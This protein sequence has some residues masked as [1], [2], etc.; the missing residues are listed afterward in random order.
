LIPTSKI[1]LWV[2]VVVI[3]G[4][5]IMIARSVRQRLPHIGSLRVVCAIALLSLVALTT[6]CARQVHLSGQVFTSLDLTQPFY[7]T[8]KGNP[9]RPASNLGPLSV[10]DIRLI[11]DGDLDGRVGRGG[12]RRDGRFDLKIASPLFFG[13]NTVT[14]VLRQPGFKATRFDLSVDKVNE[15]AASTP[16]GEPMFEFWLPPLQPE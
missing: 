6:G 1:I 16:E 12:T 2:S 14:L 8:P 15:A 10:T 3:A 5:K 9:P 7:R 4:P 11:P 13:Y